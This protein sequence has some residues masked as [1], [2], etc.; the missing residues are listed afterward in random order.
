MNRPSAPQLL[1]VS[2]LLPRGVWVDRHIPH[3]RGHALDDLEQLAGRGTR[4]PQVR[5][6]RRPSRVLQLLVE[7]LSSSCLAPK[8][9][10]GKNPSMNASTDALEV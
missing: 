6:L 9:S 8:D 2:H 3:I 5:L 1:G 4:E 10:S 7:G